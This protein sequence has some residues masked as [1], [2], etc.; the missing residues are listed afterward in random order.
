LWQLL[1]SSTNLDFGHS[2]ALKFSRVQLLIEPSRDH[3]PFHFQ[4][5]CRWENIKP[6]N[7]Y[8]EGKGTPKCFTQLKSMVRV[9]SM[10]SI[11]AEVLLE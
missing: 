8:C 10:V 11:A 9:K 3:F 4:L 6:S 7:H 1:L 5:G 2:C